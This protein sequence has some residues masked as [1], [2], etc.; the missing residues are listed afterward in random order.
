[1]FSSSFLYLGI[2]TQRRARPLSYDSGRCVF[3]NLGQ[4]LGSRAGVPV[5]ID[6][7]ALEKLAREASSGPWQRMPD[8]DALDEGV[9]PW[10]RVALTGKIN[11][12]VDLN[13]SHLPNA[14][15]IAASN[16][17]TV[18]ALIAEL[19]DLRRRLLFD[20]SQCVGEHIWPRHPRYEA[21]MGIVRGL[22]AKKPPAH[23]GTCL[24]CHFADED[25]TKVNHSLG[26]PWRRARELVGGGE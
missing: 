17:S 18:L 10:V 9:T 3:K 16:P 24:L 5:T 15:F 26:C 14:D 21:L 12:R 20:T 23:N 1:M 6:L 13:L 7:D 11:G 4:P 22:A 25:E 2:K 19:R 8:D